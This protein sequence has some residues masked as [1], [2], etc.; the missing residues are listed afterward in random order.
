[1][2]LEAAKYLEAPA[3]SS[4]GAAEFNALVAETAPRLFRLA[5]RLLGSQADAEDVLQ[6]SYV[7]AF[8]AWRQGGFQQRA[9]G[10]TW[11]YRIVTHVALNHLRAR[12]RKDARDAAYGASGPDALQALETNAELRQ[13]AT[14]LDLLP[15]EQ[16]TALVLKELEGLSAP[17]VA[18]VL[19][20]SVGAVEQ[21]VHRARTT[22]RKMCE[23]E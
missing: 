19:G 4:P 17:E 6:E 23:R 2:T 7:R 18:Q 11:L 20:C 13:L 21:R 15:E 12:T 3:A 5:A 1:M 22:L 9:T 8:D 10:M 14:W 16:R